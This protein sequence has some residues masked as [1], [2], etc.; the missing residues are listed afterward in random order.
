MMRSRSIIILAI[1]LFFL[2]YLMSNA[3]ADD[4]EAKVYNLDESIVEA[5]A[6]NY[7][8]KAKKEKIEEAMYVKKQAN[9]EFLPK[10]STSYGYT[11]LDKVN[12]VA[13]SYGDIYDTNGNQI[14]TVVISG[15]NLNSLDNFQWKTSLK[16]P[17][18]TG[19]ALT[20]AKELAELGIDIAKVDLELEKLDLALKVKNSYFNILTA[21]ASISVAQDAV[22]S[23]ESHVEHAS[24]FYKVGMIP[25]NDLLKSEVE[26]GKAK[27]QLVRAQNSAKL[28]R[29][30]FNVV[31]AR[32]INNPVDVED[33]LIYSP[34][35]PDF[36][37]LFE[38]ALKNRPEIKALD[39]NDMQIDQQIRLA[40]SDY[41][42][43]AALTADYVRE[44]DD[45][46]VSGSLFHDEEAWSV[47]AGLTW[48]FWEW[49]RTKNAV[50]EKESLKFQLAQTRKTLEEGIQLEIKQAILELDQA[51]KNIPPTK[52]SVEQAEENLRVSQ[53]RYAAQVT[54]S[55]EVLDAQTLLAEARINYIRAVYD[56]TLAKANLLRAVGE[57]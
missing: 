23:L 41:Y 51:E 28:A 50:K 10:L 53:E 24:N 48:T 34:E 35:T 40:K 13:N 11:R 6:N 46:S 12:R 4:T 52:K 56:H 32:P 39:I 26:L 29:S 22:E 15:Y 17:L 54:T 1:T 43:S 36:N 55:T 19:F 30:A 47:T 33:L 2:I 20:S 7:T 57:Y 44:G 25:I 42:P 18:F 5:F 38:R 8:L 27:Y 14:G 16:Q 49:G 3:I 21:D 37:K 31:L 9:A 45:P